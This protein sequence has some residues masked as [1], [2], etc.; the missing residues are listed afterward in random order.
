MRTGKIGWLFAVAALVLFATI[1]AR[2]QAPTAIAFVNVPQALERVPGFQS[3]Q[4][5]FQ[6]ELDRNEQQL[7]GMQD[8]L[9]AL[10]Q[11]FES[12]QGTMNAASRQQRVEQIRELQRQLQTRA[13][14]LE[15]RAYERE[16]ALLGPL[17]DRVQQAIDGLRVERGLSA[18]L[19]VTAEGSGLVSVDPALDLT[20]AVIERVRR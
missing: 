11:Q 10:I 16:T 14:E 1:A 6:Q 18:I 3:A 9:D 20:P 7:K 4:Q 2:P 17:Q 19:D 12:Q 8:Q 5:T 15:E 13:Q